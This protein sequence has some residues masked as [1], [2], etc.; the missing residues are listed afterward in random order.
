MPHP[1]SK[2]FVVHV[3]LGSEMEE[4]HV[5][6]RDASSAESRAIRA[7]AWHPYESRPLDLGL[8]HAEV[9]A[10]QMYKDSDVAN[11]PVPRTAQS[12]P[13]PRCDGTG[14]VPKPRR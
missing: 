6:A 4:V 2:Q 10:E 1:G 12:K 9:I 5:G 3:Y 11:W 13:C 14:L 7:Y 8:Y